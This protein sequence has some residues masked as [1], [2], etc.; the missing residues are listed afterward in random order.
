MLLLLRLS[1]SGVLLLSAGLKV[2]RR[3]DVAASAKALGVPGKVAGPVAVTLP[4]IEF[5]LAA[6]LVLETIA[7]WTSIAAAALLAAF[8]VVVA[9]NVVRGR[10]VPCNCFGSVSTHAIS[11]WTVSRNLGLTAAAAVLVAAGPDRSS[12]L[13]TWL[14][15]HVP[16]HGVATSAV[17]LWAGLALTLVHLLAVRRAPGVPAATRSEE[18]SVTAELAALVAGNGPTVAV[19]VKPGCPPCHALSAELVQWQQGYGLAVVCAGTPTAC[20]EEFPRLD[21]RQLVHDADRR[22]AGAAGVSG[23]PA[24]VRLAPDGEVVARVEGAAAIR[25]LAAN[26][27]S[28]ATSRGPLTHGDDA[29]SLWLWT[30]GRRVISL[31]EFAGRMSVLV[32][33]DPACSWC[34]RLLPDLDLWRRTLPDDAPRAVVVTR[35]DLRL[36]AVQGVSDIAFFDDG[37]M[38]TA[39]EVAETPSAVLLDASVRVASDVA[40]GT[41]ATLELARRAEAV[42]AVARRLVSASR[43][44][45]STSRE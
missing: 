24:A 7:W 38:H 15:A 25:A 1:L 36:V 41:D 45:F 42:S 21:E 34:Q 26:V 16:T 29:S 44:V 27:L 10:R 35:A 8:G 6:G 22:L 28:P 18:I 43:G 30:P 37:S 11:W 9:A 13:D 4:I 33:W 14:V 40:V 20:A 32:F 23:T 5:A 3:T 17:L 19:F 31:A 12:G 2:G 39:F